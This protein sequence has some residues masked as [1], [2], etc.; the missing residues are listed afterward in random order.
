MKI[1]LSELKD[2]IAWI[3]A[4]TN[5]EVIN[6]EEDDKICFIKCFDKN[7]RQV[8][9]EVFGTDNALMPKLTRTERLPPRKL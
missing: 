7:D 9:V 5:E 4:N 2:A 3:E 1:K 6:I 8:Q